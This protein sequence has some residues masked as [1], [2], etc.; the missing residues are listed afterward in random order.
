MEALKVIGGLDDGE[1]AFGEDRM[2]QL[3]RGRPSPA[4]DVGE[5]EQPDAVI[6]LLYS[7]PLTGQDG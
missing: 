5:A 3:G 2:L 6:D 4:A 7:K 1:F